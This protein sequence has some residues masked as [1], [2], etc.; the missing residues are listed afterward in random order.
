[1]RKY[2]Q[3]NLRKKGK[4]AMDPT[5]FTLDINHSINNNGYFTKPIDYSLVQSLSMV[6]VYQLV[7]LMDPITQVLGCHHLTKHFAA[8]KIELS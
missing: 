6:K 2:L 8:T 1:M 4:K 5:S 3:P 7:I